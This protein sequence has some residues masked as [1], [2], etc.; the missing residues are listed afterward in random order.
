MADPSLVQAI[1]GKINDGKFS[2]TDLDK[3]NDLILARV[4]N[5]TES[6]VQ[7]LEPQSSSP[8]QIFKERAASYTKGALLIIQHHPD[9]EPNKK[10]ELTKMINQLGTKIT[11]DFDSPLSADDANE[12][13]SQHMVQLISTIATNTGTQ[14]LDAVQQELVKAEVMAMW[15]IGRQEAITVTKYTDPISQENRFVAQIDEPIC[16]LTF[17]QAEEYFKIFNDEAELPEWFKGMPAWQQEALRTRIEPAFNEYKE[18]NN[19]S[20]VQDRLNKDLTSIP[21]AMR[22]V[23]G[24]ANHTRH[25]LVIYN[26]AGEVLKHAYT[27]NR[28]SIFYPIGF[29]KEARQQDGTRV[30]QQNLEQAIQSDNLSKPLERYIEHWGKPEEGEV[31]TL[32]VNFQTLISPLKYEFLLPEENANIIK[33]KIKFIEAYNKADHPPL[34]VNGVQVKLVLFGT[35]HALNSMR[36]IPLVMDQKTMLSLNEM[37]H[38]EDHVRE[39]IEEKRSAIN[40]KTVSDNAENLASSELLEESKLSVK[41]DSTKELT[42]SQK[43]ERLESICD[44]YHEVATSKSKVGNHRQMYLSSLEEMMNDA[45]GG[46]VIGGCKSAKDRRGMQLCHTDAM[47]IYEQ[48]YGKLP[49][50][51]DKPGSDERQNF[52]DIMSKLFLSNHHQYVS[53]QNANGCLGLKSVD[54]VL[55]KDIQ[56]GIKKL[57][58]TVFKENKLN[59]NLNKPSIEI[60]SST[61]LELIKKVPSTFSKMMFNNTPETEDIKLKTDATSA[62]IKKSDNKELSNTL[63]SSLNPGRSSGV[64]ILVGVSL[65]ALSV[66]AP[67]LAP[68][69]AVVMVAGLLIGAKNILGN[70]KQS[71]FSN[72]ATVSGSTKLIQDEINPHANNSVIND[73]EKS[74]KESNENQPD[75]P[76]EDQPESHTN[77]SASESRSSNSA[78]SSMT[79][80]AI[81]TTGSETEQLKESLSCQ[82]AKPNS[83][84]SLS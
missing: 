64:A 71:S 30:A 60:K 67:P 73:V 53:H 78:S 34:E 82:E 21:T 80:I 31:V 26:E 43:L 20:A 76:K 49:S 68:I 25:S 42:L 65:L 14:D 9:L 69:G 8:S 17:S 84:T 7:P 66:V 24:L 39:F 38:F 10:N 52:V 12:K 5:F 47:H 32:A 72:T 37:Q 79:T 50:Y 48:S 74:A 57:N 46:L 58:P 77:T 54:D 28:N 40:D 35:N 29:D 41:S 19:K 11:A 16:N 36:H 13:F 4:R 3:N 59:S 6:S 55:P 15:E 44:Q 51:F 27:S 2:L 63:L 56:E 1:G 75:Q 70:M 83:V 23:P 22:G 61:Y 18:N 62:L 81:N 45:M 33:E